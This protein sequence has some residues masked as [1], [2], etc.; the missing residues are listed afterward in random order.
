MILEVKK[1]ISY[2]ELKIIG[3]YL[4][5]VMLLVY[6]C[7]VGLV[8]VMRMVISLMNVQSVVIIR[9]QFNLYR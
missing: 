1:I 3:G 4:C 5:Q 7:V 9:S 8:G 2:V 6:V